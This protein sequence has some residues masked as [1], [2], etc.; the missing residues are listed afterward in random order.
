MNA[1]EN[2]NKRPIGLLSIDVKTIYDRII[3]AGV[4]DTITYAEMEGLIGRPVREHGQWILMSARR[5]AL[6]QN[7]MV[8]GVV[9]KIGVRRL[10]DSEIVN[11]GA[12]FVGRVHRLSNKAVRTIACVQDFNALPAE[13]KLKHG[14]YA[15]AMGMLAYIT[16]EKQIKRLEERVDKAQASLPLQKTLDAFKES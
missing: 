16:R 11:L 10:S 3:K 7:G 14:T 6:M 12:D 5:R 9:K 13:A 8:F 4:G 15:S 1:T 2:K